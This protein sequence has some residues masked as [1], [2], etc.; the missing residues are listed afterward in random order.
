MLCLPLLGHA[1]TTVTEAQ[2]KAAEAKRMAEE[3]A[4]KAEEARIAAL[5]AEEAAKEAEAA[6]ALAEKAQAEAEANAARN[7]AKEVE[8]KTVIEKTSEEKNAEISKW[9]EQAKA[10]PKSPSAPEVNYM[11]GAVPE[12]DGKVEWKLSLDIPGLGANDIFDKTGQLIYEMT[13]GANQTENSRIVITDKENHTI[14]ATFQE[15][16]V[17]AKRALS[18]DETEFHYTLHAQCQDGH[19]DLTMCRISYLYEANRGKGTRYKAE[20]WITDKYSM[21]KAKTRLF[22]VS[23]KFRRSTIDR[24]DEIFN[25][26][27][28]RF[29]AT[30]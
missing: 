26:V 18:L 21:N 13:Q 27:K 20:E 6:R 29:N 12:N 4:R 28:A 23:G 30:K 1:Q 14:A 5:K 10:A 15:M 22:P 16:L 8:Q 11:E 25:M 17:L 24:K 3:A 9:A 2:Q 19:L 7:V